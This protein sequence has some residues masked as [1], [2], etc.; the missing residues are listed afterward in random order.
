VDVIISNCVINLS[1]DKPAVFREAFR[2]LRPGG[3]LH[4]S[5]VVLLRELSAAEQEDLELWAG[6]VTGALSIGDYEAGL[7]AA[8][9]EDIQIVVEA[10]RDTAAAGVPWR[11]AL[12]NARR[13]RPDVTGKPRLDPAAER[14]D[15]VSASAA[16]DVPCCGPG[17]PAGSRCC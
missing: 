5:D 6:C 9:F 3:R 13:T 4:V 10:A 11:N 16:T 2:V 17:A 12:I 15:V 1:P 14:L 7:R 8:G